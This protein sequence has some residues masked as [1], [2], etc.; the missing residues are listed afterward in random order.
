MFGETAEQPQTPAPDVDALIGWGW[1]YVLN[2]RAAIERGRPWQAERWISAVRDQG[3]ALAC[4]RHGLPAE[5]GRGIDRLAPEVT[6]GW[7]GALVRSIDASDL[8]RALAVAAEAFLREVAETKP[9]LAE[10]LREPLS[11]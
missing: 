3:L 1:I 2:A 4:V 7:E 8:R 9:A 6:T 10:R 11:A 5:H